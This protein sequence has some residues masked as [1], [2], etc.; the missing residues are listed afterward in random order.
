MGIWCVCWGVCPQRIMCVVGG[1]VTAA[2]G[3]PGGLTVCWLIRGAS[4]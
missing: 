2:E 1:A 3:G 4:H